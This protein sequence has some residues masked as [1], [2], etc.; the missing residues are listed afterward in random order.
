MVPI[1]KENQL[2]LGKC[3]DLQFGL[4]LS[5]G[6]PGRN[7]LEVRGEE[8]GEAAQRRPRLHSA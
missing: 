2:R 7:G 6:A 5:V 3:T 8:A 1:A 4:A